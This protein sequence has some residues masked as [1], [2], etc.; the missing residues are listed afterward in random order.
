MK[1]KYAFVFGL[2]F[3]FGFTFGLAFT[4]VSTAHAAPPTPG[5]CVVAWCDEFHIEPSTEG[6]WVYGGPG[7]WTCVCDGTNDCDRHNP[8]DITP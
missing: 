5:C 6:H 3:L 1:S 8:C 2:L 7:N 4:L